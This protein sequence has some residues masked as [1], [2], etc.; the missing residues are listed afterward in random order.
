MNDLAS[1]HFYLKETYGVK[2]GRLIGKERV[3]VPFVVP[4][5]TPVFGEHNGQD[6]PG[7]IGFMEKF[8]LRKHL[9]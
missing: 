7:G 9:A 4:E 5:K 3:A 6:R 2:A 1:P 8:D